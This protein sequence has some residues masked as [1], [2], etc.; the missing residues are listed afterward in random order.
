VRVRPIP[1]VV[2][3]FVAAL[4]LPTIAS[5]KPRAIQGRCHF[6]S[7]T[8]M[9]AL[10]HHP[11]FTSQYA[12]VVRRGVTYCMSLAELSVGD[13][14]W[15]DDVSSNGSVI[16]LEDGSTWLVS[17]LDTVTTSIWL[18][19][20]SIKVARSRDPGYPYLLINTDEGETA[21]ARFVAS[22]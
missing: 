14:H 5:G 21:A 1:V 18:T 20:D 7:V 22:H 4:A 16:T 10:S 13:G 3:G 6:V 15:I 2:C 11:R 12:Y 19:V 8:R 17:P 9:W